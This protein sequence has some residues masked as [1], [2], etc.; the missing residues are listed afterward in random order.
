MLPLL[1]GFLECRGTTSV[2][3]RRSGQTEAKEFFGEYSPA[4]V[5]ENREIVPVT[6]LIHI[7]TYS[8]ICFNY[9]IVNSLEGFMCFGMAIAA[10]HAESN[11]WG[12]E[13]L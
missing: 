3:G 7:G 5:A 4:S 10:R 2:T 11:V 13:A 1:L 9:I 12:W 6:R 8:G